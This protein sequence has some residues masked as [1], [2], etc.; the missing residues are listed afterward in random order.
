MTV[1]G[2]IDPGPAEERIVSELCLRNGRP[3]ANW[4]R[5]PTSYWETWRE[6]C[7]LCDRIVVNSAWSRKALIERGCARGKNPRCTVGL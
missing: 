3:I 6:E 7:D 5:V 1:L 4:Q 2:Q